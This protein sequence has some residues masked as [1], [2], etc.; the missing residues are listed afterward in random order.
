MDFILRFQAFKS[1]QVRRGRERGRGRGRKN[2]DSAVENEPALAIIIST[3]LQ[4]FSLVAQ[5]FIDATRFE[6]LVVHMRNRAKIT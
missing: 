5:V 3:I 6:N 1:F 2:V 4:N